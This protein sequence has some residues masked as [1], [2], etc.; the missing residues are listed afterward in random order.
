MNTKD[1]QSNVITFLRF[2]LIVGVVFIHNTSIEV[3]LPGAEF[4]TIIE[5]T[6][7]FAGCSALFSQIL[8][9]VAVPLFF[10]IS[11]FLFFRNIENFTKSVYLKKLKRRGKTLL[12]PYLFWNITALLIYYIA[13][14]IP[15]LSGW[16]NSNVEYTFQYLRE[17]MWGIMDKEE[18]MTYPI[19]Y[20]FWFIRDLMVTVILT[21]VIYFYVKRTKIY[22]VLLLGILWF[23]NWW[24]SFIGIR[25]LSITAIFFFTVGAWFGI[26][27]RN[28]VDDMGKIQRW[29][30][31]LYPLLLVADF[32]TRDYV[33]NSFIHRAGI[34][35][36]IVF[37]INFVSYLL[38]TRKIGINQFLA[39]SSFFLFAIHDPFLLSKIKKVLYVT[40]NPQSDLVTTALYFLL[41]IVV[42]FIALGLYYV[43]KRFM[44]KFTAIITGG[45]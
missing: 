5:R 26:N 15:A 36:G 11:G 20:Q 28:I 33:A 44:P 14:H 43:L 38:K 37:W 18:T 23:L 9:R 30:F 39:S 6:P 19:V 7:I 27:R 34:I 12:I 4:G 13:R 35:V 40:F 45:R 24:F 32:L 21:P 16:F 29:S 3:L 41:V 25:G 22:G 8:A 10:F 31:M 1:L 42:V 2:P 17:S